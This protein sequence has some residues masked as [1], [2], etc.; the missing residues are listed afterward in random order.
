MVQQHP[1]PNAPSCQ[2]PILCL[3]L[4]PDYGAI[5][6][7]RVWEEQLSGYN[8]R[9]LVPRR[10]GG[11]VACSHLHTVKFS[12]KPELELQPEY[13]NLQNTSVAGVSY[14]GLEPSLPVEDDLTC[15]NIQLSRWL[16]TTIKILYAVCSG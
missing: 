13:I 14:Q 12:P 11:S 7:C 2:T 15:R 9:L 6:R 10:G 5:S 8:Q 3:P 16:I 4:A 1:A